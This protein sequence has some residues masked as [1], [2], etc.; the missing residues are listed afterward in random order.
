MRV[1]ISGALDSTGAAQVGNDVRWAA[2]R[3]TSVVTIDVTDNGFVDS[4]G[5]RLLIEAQ[6]MAAARH[7]EFRLL[8][9]AALQHLL[10]ITGLTRLAHHNARPALRA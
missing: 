4:S 10:D 8:P 5:L 7:I 2:L 1:V 9:S 3:S 6:Q